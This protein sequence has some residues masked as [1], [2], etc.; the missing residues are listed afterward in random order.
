[1]KKRSKKKFTYQGNTYEL[2]EY[3]ELQLQ[4]KHHQGP[5]EPLIQFDSRIKNGK[6]WIDDDWSEPRG[7]FT[8]SKAPRLLRIF[9]EQAEY[10]LNIKIK[11]NSPVIKHFLDNVIA[12]P[13]AEMR[14]LFSLSNELDELQFI[15]KAKSNHKRLELYQQS[16]NVAQASRQHY[17]KKESIEEVRVGEMQCFLGKR[18]FNC[19]NEHFWYQIKKQLF[20]V[21]DKTAL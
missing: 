12:G 10:L 3:L 4:I 14:K 5:N 16:Q 11:P 18:Y 20:K 19:D 8:L 7:R 6:L 17:W 13:T 2:P 21:I 15:N 1:M 9:K